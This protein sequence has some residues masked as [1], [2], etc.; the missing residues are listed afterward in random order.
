[1][2]APTCPLGKLDV[3]GAASRCSTS[4]RVRPT[5]AAA[6][7]NTEDCTEIAI[8]G[9]TASHHCLVRHHSR[10]TTTTQAEMMK[11]VAPMF[12][13]TDVIASIA[14]VRPATSR[15]LSSA[16]PG[17]G[18]SGPT[19]VRP[20]PTM[21]A[22]SASAGTTVR[23]SRSCRASRTVGAEASSSY[24]RTKDTQATSGCGAGTGG[25]QP[26]YPRNEAPAI[27]PPRAIPA[28]TSDG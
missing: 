28:T 2:D 4:G 15:S 17:R 9:T 6:V 18:C 10:A 13:H 12:D 7:T 24:R 1:M 3:G 11:N 27:A 19:I 22:Q 14:G 5:T 23:C 25:F 8:A 16:S 26:T 20:R 21:T